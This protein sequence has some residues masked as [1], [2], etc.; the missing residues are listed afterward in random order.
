KDWAF[1]IR[2]ASD[3]AAAFEIIHNRNILVGDVNQKNVLVSEDGSVSVIDCDSFQVQADG[4]L[5]PCEVGVYEFTP[6]E[7]QARNRGSL[8]RTLDHD[9]WALAVLVFHLL[10][11]GHHPYFG[12]PLDSGDAIAHE[13]AIREFQFAFSGSSSDLRQ[14]PPRF[15]PTLD[16]IS[17]Q[18]A[19][20]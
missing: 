10:F 12:H 20:L 11:M 1:L 8:A 6:P 7:L 9:R 19:G 16:C 14:K 17:P 15:C 3:C 18:L 4:K 5:W 13:K 2:V